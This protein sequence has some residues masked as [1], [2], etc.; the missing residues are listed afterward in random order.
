MRSDGLARSVHDVFDAS[1]GD[2]VGHRADGAF[3]A[4]GAD[5]A[6]QQGDHL[7]VAGGDEV[8]VRRLPGG[9]D[10]VA[11]WGVLDVPGAKGGD[12]GGADLGAGDGVEY[13]YASRPGRRRPSR[14]PLTP[15][16]GSSSRGCPGGSEAV[17]RRGRRA[18]IWRPGWFRRGLPASLLRVGRGRGNRRAGGRASGTVTTAISPGRV[19]L[20]TRA[21]GGRRRTFRRRRTRR[22]RS[23]RRTRPSARWSGRGSRPPGSPRAESSSRTPATSPPARN[24]IAS[25]GPRGRSS[26]RHWPYRSRGC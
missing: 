5:G 23:P 21:T 17:R 2:D 9:R 18:S 19:L 8:A 11:P 22:Y 10:Q 14:R 3:A 16:G 4:S 13:P 15:G 20:V 1:L 26:R 24:G 7:V 12:P 6:P 25:T